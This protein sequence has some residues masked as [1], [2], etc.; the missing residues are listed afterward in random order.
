M[1][2]CLLCFVLLAVGAVLATV[3]GE[4]NEFQHNHH[5]RSSEDWPEEAIKE[6]VYRRV[7]V[8]DI[9][10]PVECLYHDGTYVTHSTG[11]TGA[12]VKGFGI[13]YDASLKTFVSSA[14]KVIE[15]FQLKT[16]EQEFE[17]IHL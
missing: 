14:S 2:L 1:R 13:T 15:Q 10:L 6:C 8:R 12:V 7:M 5:L 9:E 17:E 16:G 4:A 11:L 3:S